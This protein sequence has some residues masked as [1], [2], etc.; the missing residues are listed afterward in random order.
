VEPERRIVSV[1]FADLVGF[2][3]LSESLDAEDVR[4]VQDAYFDAVRETV[5]RYRGT[6]EKFIGDAAVAVFGVSRTEDDD[7]ER[8]VAAGLA[9]TAAVEHLGGRLGLDADVL[10][11]RVGVNTGEALVAAAATD[12]GPVTGDTVNVAARLQAAAP[13]GGVLVGPA[14]A[15]AVREAFELEP[16][17]LLALKGKAD[18]VAASVV[19]RARAVRSRDEAMGGLRAPLLGRE[20][21][22]RRLLDTFERLDGES[23][24]VLVVAPPGTGKSRLVDELAHA[25]PRGTRILHARS[26]PDALGPYEPIA[27]LVAGAA[28]DSRGDALVERLAAQLSSER[29]R[30]VAEELDAL[31]GADPTPRDRRGTSDRDASFEAWLEALDALAGGLPDLWILEDVH[32]AS[33]DTLAFLQHAVRRTGAQRLVVATARPAL[34]DRLSPDAGSVL[35]LLPLSLSDTAGLVA[36]LI[37]DALPAAVVSAIADRSDGNPL[38]VEELLR[39][40]IA[41]GVLSPDAAGGWHLTTE[42]ADVPLP[43]TVQAIYAAQIDDL[44]AEARLLARRASVAG[45][46]FPGAALPSLEVDD[47]EKGLAPLLRRSLVTGPEN[48]PLLGAT[49]RFRHALL[50]DAGYLSLPRAERARLHLRLARWLE[51]EAGDEPAALA[52]LVGR[53]YASA[54]ETA[55]TL[56]REI[57]RGTSSADASALAAAWLERG[58]R[59]ALELAAVETAA[60]ALRRALD[61]TPAGEPLDRAR[62]LTLLGEATASAANMDEGSAY[63][64]EALGL[65]TAAFEATGSDHARETFAAAVVALG[66]ARNQQIRFADAAELARRGLD[67]LGLRNDAATARLLLLRAFSANASTDEAEQPSAD[68]RQ[69]VEIARAIGDRG[70]ELDARERA[71]M[72]TDDSTPDEWAS[73]AQL[74]VELG[75]PEVAARA[76]RVQASVLVDDNARASLVVIDE[77]D[78]LAHARGLTEARAWCD[79]TRAEALAVLGAWDD[80]TAAGLRAIALGQE[81][82]YHRAVVRT[83]HAILPI[84]AAREDASLLARAVAWYAARADALARVDSPYG[85]VM[86]GANHLRFAAAGLEPRFVPA[87]ATMSDGFALAYAGPSW[88]FALETVF[89]AWLQAD[90]L[91]AATEALAVLRPAQERVHTRLGQAL[92]DLLSARLDEASGSGESEISARHALAGFREVEAPWWSARAIRVLERGGAAGADLVAEVVETERRLGAIAT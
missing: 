54:A 21:E 34:L 48:D 82:G 40:W 16:A 51:T 20:D 8:A 75:R 29:A 24:L 12:R 68:A 6:L 59:H 53:H 14:T 15:L 83:W 80:A 25:A 27:Q 37:G 46:R 36:A 52:E 1:L 41:V 26:R 30:A 3:S 73:L 56:V 61:H 67:T 87:F 4:T 72:L 65:A 32:W 18:P 86:S 57:D 85:R 45:R 42:A 23:A 17:E 10:R 55:P 22:L 74:A 78:R 38:F 70:L 69:A 71:L 7:A 35:E 33:G 13:P 76:L 39:T 62:R 79:Y 81:H 5:G 66:N 58:A 50:R 9:L 49:Y 60:A 19:L 88:F 77:A 63:L 43:T 31:L 2:T 91:A 64:E 47:K 92:V 89:E 84:A 11:L 90:A 44:P 28:G